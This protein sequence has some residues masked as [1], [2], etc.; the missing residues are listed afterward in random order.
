MAGRSRSVG[1]PPFLALASHPL[2]WQMLSELAETDRQVRELTRIVDQPQA[3]VSYHLAQLRAGGLVS[4]RRS[5]FDGR[6]AY[7]RVHLDRCGAMLAAA[8]AALHPA[9][10]HTDGTAP[11]RDERHRATSV[12]FVC[13]GNGARSQIAEAL[14]RAGADERHIDV[15]SAGSHPKPVHP[16]AVAVMAER[17]IDIS[18]VRSKSLAQF[19]GHPFDYVVTQCDKV[20]E[21]CPEPPQPARTMHW[22]IEDPTSVRG[23]LRS[24]MPVFRALA[25][26][27]EGRIRFLLARIDDPATPTTRAHA[28]EKAHVR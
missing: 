6:A 12:L 10:A 1:V 8:G 21:V 18:G 15:A 26:D 2:R 22:S 5:S 17:G 7:Y 20:R 19:E 16:N 27:L 23:S 28:K 25:N 4:A 9:L 13:T 11:R 24:T 3:V 14:L